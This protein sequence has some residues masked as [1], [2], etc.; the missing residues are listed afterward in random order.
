M[1]IYLDHATSTPIRREVLDRMLPYFCSTYAH[2][3]GSH[4]LGRQS[5]QV[6]EG[7]RRAIAQVLD[8][9]PR[10]FSFTSGVDQSNQLALL[11]LARNYGPPG[12]HI[13]T[14]EGEPQSVL[15]SCRLLE[16]EG[17]RVTYL[18]L[19]E[20][21][22]VD[23][24][25]AKQAL[26]ADT[27]LASF[28]LVN[29]DLGTLQP[30]AELAR[31]CGERRVLVHCDATHAELLDF[32]IAQLGVHSLA[33]ASHT[34]YGPQGVGALWLDKSLSLKSRWDAGHQPPRENSNIAVIVGFAEALCLLADE[35]LDLSRRLRGLSEELVAR[36]PQGCSASPS[37]HPGIVAVR[38]PELDSHALLEEL[39]LRGVCLSLTRCGALRFSLGRQTTRSD[40]DATLQALEQSLAHLLAGL[41]RAA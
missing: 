35:R 14:T 41:R 36:L 7:A 25:E 6:L 21:G 13:L 37:D 17:F 29:P 40:I 23:L 11:A 1:A 18:P 8:V 10:E 5:N 31:L 27:F 26:E 9:L 3:S 32:E 38:Y 19:D 33:L 20:W 22:R 24:D 2:A 15:E 16:K 12:G 34:I 39:D 28:S 4:S 30:I